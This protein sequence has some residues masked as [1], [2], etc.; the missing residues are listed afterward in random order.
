MPGVRGAEVDNDPLFP[1]AMEKTFKVNIVKIHFL[2]AIRFYSFSC[3]RPLLILFAVAARFRFFFSRFPAFA[4]SNTIIPVAEFP[5]LRALRRF[6]RRDGSA[7]RFAG[8]GADTGVSIHRLREPVLLYGEI[9]TSDR[10][11]IESV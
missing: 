10:A 8:E 3:P 4:R 2:P 1:L 9:K 6:R 11:R 7:G 5:Y